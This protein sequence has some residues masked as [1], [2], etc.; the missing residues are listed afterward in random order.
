MKLSLNDIGELKPQELELIYLLR[1]V[2]RY[3]EV[4]ILTRDGLPQDILKT[5]AR[6]RLG[7]LSTDELDI[8]GR[9]FDNRHSS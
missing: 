6:T 1:H 9:Q 8:M 7:N 3:G 4:T 2:Y 5:V